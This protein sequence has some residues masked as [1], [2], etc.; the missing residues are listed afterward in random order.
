MANRLGDDFE[1]ELRF[2]RLHAG[3][4][5][6]FITSLAGSHAIVFGRRIFLAPSAHGA[7]E[8]DADSAADLLAHELTHV[9]QYRRYGMAA[10]LG[11]YLGEYFGRRF[12]GLSH[13][14]AYLAISFERDA[15][16]AGQARPCFSSSRENRGSDR[17]G[18]KNG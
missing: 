4:L 14:D 17:S 1:D 6:R 11:R 18:S 16:S 15:R 3:R 8:S 9:R 13:R 7:L 12:A 5:A 10:F 2:A